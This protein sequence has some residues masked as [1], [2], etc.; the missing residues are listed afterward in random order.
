MS[1]SV[2]SIKTILDTVARAL[3]ATTFLASVAV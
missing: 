1:P 2:Y 3:A